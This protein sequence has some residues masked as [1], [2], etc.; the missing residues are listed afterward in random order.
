MRVENDGYNITI[1]FIGR[2]KDGLNVWE[3][4]KNDANSIEIFLGFS[5][6]DGWGTTEGMCIPLQNIAEIY[7]GLSMVLNSNPFSY[8]C[9]LPLINSNEEFI[10][11]SAD[12]VSNGILFFL[13]IYDN[14]CDYVQLTEV[15]TTA[16][17]ND[18]LLEIKSVL[19]KYPII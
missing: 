17:F 3:Q 13:K 18:I 12:I 4:C 19:D 9:N 14:L 1:K 16:K 6:E 2:A 15:M 11:I 8:S 5:V 10:A 7:N